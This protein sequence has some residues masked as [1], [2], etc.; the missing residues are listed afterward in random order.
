MLRTNR[1]FNS[2]EIKKNIKIQDKNEEGNYKT[3]E[4]RSHI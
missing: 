3:H 2:K 1:D 4:N